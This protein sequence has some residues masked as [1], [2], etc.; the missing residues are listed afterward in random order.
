M[1]KKKPKTRGRILSNAASTTTTR[2]ADAVA[3]VQPIAKGPY[4]FEFQ[5]V[6]RSASERAAEVGLGAQR[7]GCGGGERVGRT[8]PARHGPAVAMP[9][10]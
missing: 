8:A 5:T 6:A 2:P 9:P 4:N 3:A 10:C 7:E 1:T